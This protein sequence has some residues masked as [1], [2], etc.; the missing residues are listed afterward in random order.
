MP[1]IFCKDEVRQNFVYILRDNY[2]LYICNV[3][4]GCLINKQMISATMRQVI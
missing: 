3:K 1:I 2:R 4:V